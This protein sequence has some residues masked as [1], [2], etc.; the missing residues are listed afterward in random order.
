MTVL[1]EKPVISPSRRKTKP[2]LGFLGV[3]WIGRNRLEAIAASGLADL[4]AIADSSPQLATQAASIAGRPKVLSSLDELLEHDLDGIVIATPSALHAGQ[5][6][7]ALERGIAVF[8]QKPLGRDAAETRQV[9]A[10]A[11]HADA[12][13]GVDLS[14]RFLNGI[15]ETRKLLQNGELGKVYAVELAFHNAYG[16]DKEW[17]YD[18]RLSG[19]GCVIDLGIHLVD[20][21]LWGLGFP[22]V[23][24]VTSSL[25]SKGERLQ[26][27]NAVE[28][29]A[30]A[31]LDLE[32]GTSVQLSCSWRLPA[33][34]DAIIS[35]AFYGTKGGA[36]LRNLNGSFYDFNVE[37]CFGTHREVLATPQYSWG[38]RAAVNWAQQ[39][40]DGA[41]FDTSIERLI[42]VAET[43]D[44]IY[45]RKN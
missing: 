9:I 14:Y 31:R 10:A 27:F 43:L 22:K 37:R 29:Y 12:L 6:I 19:G 34:C 20:L 28:D 17:F 8:C 42:D 2:R 24:H 13:L 16:P 15:N 32:C 30:I 44:R 38:G 25:F 21:A 3:G 26:N 35:A 33:G 23:A 40:A 1:T 45:G 41:K 11:R 5:S 4:N 18:A 7:A 39:L 36:I